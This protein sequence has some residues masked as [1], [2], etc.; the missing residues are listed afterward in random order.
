MKGERHAILWL[1]VVT[2][3]G[4][5]QPD[6]VRMV[7]ACLACSHETESFSGGKNYLRRGFLIIFDFYARAFSVVVAPLPTGRLRDA[8]TSVLPVIREE[9]LSADSDEKAWKRQG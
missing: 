2:S 1:K 5:R 4:P 8:I 6:W 3:R 9:L 7:T